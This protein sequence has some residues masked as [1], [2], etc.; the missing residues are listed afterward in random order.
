MFYVNV[1]V[2]LTLAY[3]GEDFFIFDKCESDFTLNNENKLS[4]LNSEIQK[5]TLNLEKKAA[6][7]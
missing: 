4:Y 7:N 1:R 5:S 3:E 2:M 6:R